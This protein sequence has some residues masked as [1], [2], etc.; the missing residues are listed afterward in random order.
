SSSQRLHVITRIASSP[1]RF[2]A[3]ESSGF[4]YRCGGSVGVVAGGHF[5][6]VARTHHSS[7]LPCSRPSR[8]RRVEQAPV[9]G[10]GFYLH[11]TVSSKGGGSG[12]R[13]FH[14]RSALMAAGRQRL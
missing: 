8:R 7:R 14:K 11:R 6:K 12:S 1:G 3:C 4:I 10:G 13:S 9:A 2:R 5:M